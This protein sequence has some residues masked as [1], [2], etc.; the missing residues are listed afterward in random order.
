M[1]VGIVGV[2]VCY[3][4]RLVVGLGICLRRVEGRGERFLE[5]RVVNVGR[6]RDGD[7]KIWEG[8]GVRYV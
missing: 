7:R 1:F 4:W 2:F 3:I 6:D 5:G 8:G